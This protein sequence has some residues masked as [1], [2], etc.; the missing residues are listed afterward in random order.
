MGFSTSFMVVPIK[1]NSWSF[2]GFFM[3]LNISMDPDHETLHITG[4]FMSFKQ[5]YMPYSWYFSMKT[6]LI[7]IM[8]I[9]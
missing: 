8:K 2:Y 1:K 9:P 3:D 5:V 4:I 6:P 7:L